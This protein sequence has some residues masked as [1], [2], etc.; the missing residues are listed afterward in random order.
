MAE[1]TAA[2]IDDLPDSDFGY[3]EPGGTKDG[4]GRTVPR[5]LRHFPLQDAAHVRNALARLSQSPF[6]DKARAKVEAAAKKLGIGEPAG[7]GLGELKAEPMDTPQLDRW[8]SGKIPRRILVL[9]F[10][11]P[12]PKAGAPRGVDLD[13]EWFDAETDLID[14]HKALMDSRERV[15]DWHHR[16]DPTGLMK[17]AILGHVLMDATPE[18][19]GIWAD[20]WANAGEKRRELI[21][22]LER[23][24]VPLYGSSE[25]AYKK[26]SDTGHIDVWPMIRHTITTTPQNTY[27]VLPPLKAFLTA[28]TIDELPAEALKALLVGLDAST[29]ELLSGSPSAAV[30]ASALAGQ[31]AVKAG[32]VLSKKNLDDLRT[33]IELLSDLQARGLLPSEVEENND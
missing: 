7:K 29:T 3:I 2:S 15:V 26:A 33:A 10:G 28:P 6:G 23:G 19:E 25:A 20:F 18:D 11:G 16:Q 9:P 31:E 27:A 4:S 22:R 32:R 21:A 8:L 17:G 5:S 13:G 1:L 14:G 12:I 24:G 30:T